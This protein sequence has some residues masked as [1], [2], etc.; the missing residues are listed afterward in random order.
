MPRV[1]T[2]ANTIKPAA[3]IQVTTIEL[4]IGKPSG[5]AI[6]TACCGSPRSPSAPEARLVAALM[7]ISIRSHATDR[8]PTL[9]LPAFLQA[10]VACWI[11]IFNSISKS[12][13]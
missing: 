8:V 12:A 3:T 7:N 11:R 6:S 9:V 2:R 10:D 4:V 5:L 1:A 13:L